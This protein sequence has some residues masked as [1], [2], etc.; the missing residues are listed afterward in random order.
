MPDQLKS[1][2]I[3]SGLSQADLSKKLGYK[4]PQ[5]ISNIERGLCGIPADKAKQY[6][7]FIKPLKTQCMSIKRCDALNW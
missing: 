7:Q 5:L 1:Y 6:L 3:S 4:S 2:R